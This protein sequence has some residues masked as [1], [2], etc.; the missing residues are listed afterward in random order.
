MKH[1]LF[2]FLSA[3]AFAVTAKAHVLDQYL[4]VAQIA[5]EP[6]GA[7]IELR[8]VPGAQVAD[9]IFALI[10]ADGDGRISS[11]EEQAYAR[12]VLADIALE[13]D[14]QRASLTLTSIQFSTLSEMRAANGAI[15]LKLAA[16]SAWRAT[17]EHQLF[18]QNN[19]LPE[20][21]AYLANALV[22]EN[23]S[24]AINRFC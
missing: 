10:D 15:R 2:C 14:G 13:A 3:C 16:A 9:R 24:I 7:R 5:I 17:G 23:N 4:Q 20:F 8:L 1:W 11:A 21:G 12:F 6:D 18:F 19:H 22:P